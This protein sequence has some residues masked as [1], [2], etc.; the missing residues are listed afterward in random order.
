[1]GF[2]RE[3]R[4]YLFIRADQIFKHTH[5]PPPPVP[6]RVFIATD[7]QEEAEMRVTLQSFLNTISLQAD[8]HPSQ[9]GRG[10]GREDAEFT[11]L[12]HLLWFQIWNHSN[13]SSRKGL[14]TP[15]RG[16]TQIFAVNSIRLRPESPSSWA[17]QPIPQ[18]CRPTAEGA[19]PTHPARRSRGPKLNP[20]PPHAPRP[21]LLPA[22][23]FS[24]PL[25]T[26]SRTRSERFKLAP[27]AARFPG[28]L[29]D[30]R[31]DLPNSCSLPSEP[32]LSATT[33]VRSGERHR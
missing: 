22:L 16:N 25:R 3:S 33:L 23:R 28:S 24:P 11:H 7:R 18:R 32:H 31:T 26:A 10:W 5:V 27:E 29:P 13:L 14:G 1:M 9:V 21:I 20:R 15:G 17:C 8:P 12:S 19:A 2:A 4:T 30:P 6:A